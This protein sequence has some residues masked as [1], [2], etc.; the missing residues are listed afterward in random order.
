MCEMTAEQSL[1]CVVFNT[2]ADCDTAVTKFN[3]DCAACET[4]CGREGSVFTSKT[5]RKDGKWY[6]VKHPIKI[7][8]IVVAKTEEVYSDAMDTSDVQ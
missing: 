4:D 1:D 7:N 6:C 5:Q 8:D 2:E 3:E